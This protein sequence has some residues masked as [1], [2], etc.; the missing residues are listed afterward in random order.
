MAWSSRAGKLK[1][2]ND[3]IIKSKQLPVTQPPEKDSS[4]KTLSNR[5]FAVMCGM[6]CVLW[7]NKLMKWVSDQTAQQWSHHYCSCKLTEKSKKSYFWESCFKRPEANTTLKLFIM[8]LSYCS[9]FK[10]TWTHFIYKTKCFLFELCCAAA[11]RTQPLIAGG[12]FHSNS[13]CQTVATVPVTGD[14]FNMASSV[15]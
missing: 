1:N 9:C 15:H 4:G 12:R 8:Y 5:I 7:I 14:H 2:K 3:N 11:S 10:T 6:W 13:C